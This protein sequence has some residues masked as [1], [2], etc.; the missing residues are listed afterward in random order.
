M[1]S[2]AVHLP[3][4]LPIQ[5]QVV[6]EPFPSVEEIL[7]GVVRQW[8]DFTFDE[9]RPLLGR[10]GCSEG[11]F[12][13]SMKGMEKSHQPWI[14]LYHAMD[15]GMG[16]LPYACKMEVAISFLL[17]KHPNIMKAY[18]AMFQGSLVVLA[19]QVVPKAITLRQFM[20][21]EV[22]RIRKAKQKSDFR[23]CEYELRFFAIFLQRL[24]ILRYI[25]MHGIV[26]ADLKPENLLVSIYPQ[27]GL[28]ILSLIDFGQSV[29][30][31]DFKMRPRGFSRRYASPEVLC[32]SD[33]MLDGS[34]SDSYSVG[35]ILREF[36]DAVLSAL[37][38]VSSIDVT[39]SSEDDDF[40]DAWSRF[41]K[42]S[43]VVKGL[44]FRDPTAR[45]KPDSI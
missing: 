39:D 22:K 34:A 12:R 38:G 45:P 4:P 6:D 29:I 1:S 11:V 26:H 17:G 5:P 43:D 16:D 8:H 13:V 37:D 25:Y 40:Q 44:T 30:A 33:D 23:P 42:I 15:L 24:D 35:A 32:K 41:G 9:G 2:I 36:G 31:I 20:K 7:S 19:S 18:K 3:I 28:P 10:G 14:D 27:S 21:E